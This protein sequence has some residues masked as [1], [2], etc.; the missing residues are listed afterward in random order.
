MI[1]RSLKVTNFRNYDKFNITLGSKMNIFIG[2]NASGKTNILESIAILGLTKS[3]RNG[4]DSDVIKFG[5]KKALIEGRV[6]N[7][8]QIR[9]LKIEFLEKEKDIFVNNKKITKYASY[10]SNLN[11]VIFTPND[12]DIIKGS[13]SIRRNLLNM[14][15]SQIS[16]SYLVTYNEYNKILKTR[17]EYLKILFTNGI[18]DKTYLDVLTDKLVEKA[19]FIYQER[20]KYLSLINSYISDIYNNI[21]EDKRILEIEYSPN[22]SINSYEEKDLRE[23]L[24]STYNKNY[25]RELSSGMTLFGPHRDDFYFIM[26]NNIDMKIYASEGQQKCA[27][28]AYKLASIPIFKENNGSSPVLLLDDIFSEL[29]LNKRNKLLKYVSKDI[30]SIITTTD[31]KNIS[32]KTLNDAVIFKVNDGKIERS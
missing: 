14:T 27:V 10:I 5:K 26:D 16:Y 2:D 24:F 32:K 7:N 17:N 30:Q 9:D 29:D 31:L 28:L 3:F 25:R 18:A 4:L 21:T 22:I 1:I 13:P 15:L 19:V 12:L 11:I 20:Y 23:V 6:L 8:K